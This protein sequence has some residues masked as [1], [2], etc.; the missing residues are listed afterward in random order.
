MK[1]MLC[2]LVLLA[3]IAS[4]VGCAFA[5]VAE[6]LVTYVNSSRTGFMKKN[7][8]I[9]ASLEQAM[10]FYPA[11]IYEAQGIEYYKSGLNETLKVVLE[12]D[13]I[14]EVKF[15]T[16]TGYPF[17]SSAKDLEEVARYLGLVEVVE[18]CEQ[19]FS[20]TADNYGDISGRLIKELAT[21]EKGVLETDSMRLSYGVNLFS[22]AFPE[23]GTTWDY[24]MTKK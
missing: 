23:G 4:S 6:V 13:H 20:G 17:S 14:V 8:G 12:N 9:S 21:Q 5:S 24:T 2:C 22:V 1:K 18:D 19:A 7:M 11:E 3:M 16:P 10:R 15:T